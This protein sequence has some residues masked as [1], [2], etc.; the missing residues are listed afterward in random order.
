MPHVVVVEDVRKL[1]YHL[2][3]REG[4]RER[5]RDQGRLVEERARRWREEGTE[6][7]FEIGRNQGRLME[8]RV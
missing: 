1:M 6:G 8:E 5:G 3:Q 2:R 4:G 7:G